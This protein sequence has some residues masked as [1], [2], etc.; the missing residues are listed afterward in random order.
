MSTNQLDYEY[1]EWLI[2]Q[3]DTPKNDKSYLGLLERL[4]NLEFVWT[5]PNDN[6]RLTDGLDL[7]F[8]FARKRS[9]ELSLEGCTMLEL[10][11][12]LSRRLAFN[13]GGEAHHWAWRLLKNI[14]LNKMADPLSPE[15]IEKIDQVI[16]ALV[17]REYEPDGRGGFF[18]L[19]NPKEDQTQVE[20]WY[21]M[22]A[23][24]NEMI[25]L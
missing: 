15:N 4:H 8:E 1:Y 18:P 9:S 7:R 10:L 2:P 23:Y 22:Q 19:E 13:A 20:I 3:V 21:Q 14:G 11:V 6:N 24:V 25:G 12:G 17:W 5:V 16:Y